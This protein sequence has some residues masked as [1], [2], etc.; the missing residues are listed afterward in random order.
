MVKKIYQHFIFQG[1][2]KYV[3]IWIFGLKINDL[4]TLVA[5]RAVSRNTKITACANT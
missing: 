5:Y 2:P 3:Q 4:E 1:P